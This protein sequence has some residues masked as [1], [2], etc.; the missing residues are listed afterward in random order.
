[1]TGRPIPACQAGL[2]LDACP[3]AGCKTSPLALGLGSDN[4][5][6]LAS[7]AFPREAAPD[8]WRTEPFG[9]R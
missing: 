6:D 1:M 8:I 7:L 4:P 9:L 3:Q 2:V 5:T